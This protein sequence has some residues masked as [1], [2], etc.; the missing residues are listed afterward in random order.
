MGTDRNRDFATSQCRFWC[1]G[2]PLGLVWSFRE[3]EYAKGAAGD[4]SLG[5]QD[6]QPVAQEC[7][8]ADGSDDNIVD[9][10][11][12]EEIGVVFVRVDVARLNP[13]PGSPEPAE[14]C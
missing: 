5:Q 1:H 11:T 6:K 8:V 10:G 12:N 3:C 2:T 4:I 7:V 13:T 9:C 14:E